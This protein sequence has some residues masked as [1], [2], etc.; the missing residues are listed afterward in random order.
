MNLT[1]ADRRRDQFRDYLTANVAHRNFLIATT[2]TSF[3]DSMSALPTK[4]AIRN[5]AD[6]GAPSSRP[7]RQCAARRGRLPTPDFPLLRTSG[8][9]EPYGKI[10][11]IEQST[12][13]IS[14]VLVNHH[15]ISRVVKPHFQNPLRW[16]TGFVSFK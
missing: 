15:E 12:E 5:G 8:G 1:G 2:Q 3:W 6:D 9:F 13:Y 14:H 7:K 4:T 10:P 11:H 16:V